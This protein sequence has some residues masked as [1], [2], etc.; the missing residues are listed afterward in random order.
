MAKSRGRF[1]N[2]PRCRASAKD[3]VNRCPTLPSA[4]RAAAEAGVGHNPAT[5]DPG[6]H[7]GDVLGRNAIAVG[8]FVLIGWV[9]EEQGSRAIESLDRLLP[10]HLQN[11]HALEALVESPKIVERVGLAIVQ[12]REPG[13]HR[14]CAPGA[15]PPIN[16][17]PESSGLR[18]RHELASLLESCAA[19][20]PVVTFERGEGCWRQVTNVLVREDHLGVG[21][22]EDLIGSGLFGKEHRCAAA[23]GLDVSLVVR[24][25]RNE[26]PRVLAGAAPA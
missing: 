15:E 18:L 8:P 2:P 9:D 16:V 25:P 7:L 17:A 23:E 22:G 20:G 19:D 5:T 21:V 4:R 10:V 1:F 24:Q 11:L 6:E 13:H 3:I 26:S 12:G 14:F